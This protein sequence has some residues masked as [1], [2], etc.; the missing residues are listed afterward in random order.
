MS[1]TTGQN[2]IKVKGTSSLHSFSIFMSV[3]HGRNVPC[4]DIVLSAT[5]VCAV[6]CES[7]IIIT[8]TNNLLCISPDVGNIQMRYGYQKFDFSFVSF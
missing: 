6:V 7:Y 1:H 3:S 2:I 5:W 8:L 4:A